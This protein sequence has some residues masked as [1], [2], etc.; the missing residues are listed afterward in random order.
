MKTKKL[1]TYSL[2]IFILF[3]SSCAVKKYAPVSPDFYSSGLKLG[4]ILNVDTIRTFRMGAQGL[5]DVLVT[6]GNK[7]TKPLQTIEPKV[8]PVNRFKD[9]YINLLKSKGKNITLIDLEFD[10]NQFGK[11]IKP[12]DNRKYFNKDIRSLKDKYQ[13]DEVMIVKVQYG[14]SINYYGFIEMGQGGYCVADCQIINLNDNSVFYKGN[15]VGSVGL[16]GKFDTAPDYENWITAINSA[17]NKSIELEK[18]KY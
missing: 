4:L 16:K 10:D 15:S 5:L 2:I 11:F 12:A 1:F 3:L 8:N 18:T 7:Y 17:I 13:V 9:L 14:I 6:P